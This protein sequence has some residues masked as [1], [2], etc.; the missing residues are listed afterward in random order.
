MSELRAAYLEWVNLAPMNERVPA[1]IIEYK[2]TP[3]VTRRFTEPAHFNGHCCTVGHF[4][5]DA[6]GAMVPVPD[7]KVCA[8]E[9]AWRKYTRLRDAVA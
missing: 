3:D 8:R 6:S 1:Q 4:T 7:E 9:R 5:T 2:K